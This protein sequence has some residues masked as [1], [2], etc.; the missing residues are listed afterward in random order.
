MFLPC[1]EIPAARPRGVTRLRGFPGCRT[2]S[3]EFKSPGKPRPSQ[4]PVT[5]NAAL[6]RVH[7]LVSWCDCFWIPANA[8]GAKTCFWFS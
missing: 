1:P 4:P 5:P 7:L 2:F 3:T 6:Q 8:T